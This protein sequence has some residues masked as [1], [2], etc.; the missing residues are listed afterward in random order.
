MS[1]LASTEAVSLDSCYVYRHMQHVLEQSRSF[2][3][4]AWAAII[5]FGAMTVMLAI[6][7]DKEMTALA[8]NRDYL[9]T[10][11]EEVPD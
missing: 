3:Y 10:M 4:I 5:A 9:E 1:I 7:L 8:S 2:T 6:K 11:I